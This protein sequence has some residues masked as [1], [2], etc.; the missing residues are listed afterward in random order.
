MKNKY[1]KC[2]K[3]KKVLGCNGCIVKDFCQKCRKIINS[4]GAKYEK[5]SIR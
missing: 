2:K 3:P 5:L 1:C 4:K